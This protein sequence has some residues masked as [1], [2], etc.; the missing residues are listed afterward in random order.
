[1][2]A[3]GESGNPGG[4]PGLIGLPR[5][6]LFFWAALVPL[7]Y[8]PSFV[9]A[10]R[11]GALETLLI[12]AAAAI[13]F[14]AVLGADRVA[15][16]E[17]KLGPAMPVVLGLFAVFYTGI[18]TA[19]AQ[20]RLQAVGDYSQSALFGQ[21][22]WTL[23]HGHPF[24]NT[25][26]TLDGT[27]G[28]HFGVHFSPTLL[29]L[30]PFYALWPRPLVLLAFQS[31]AIALIPV[32]VYALLGPRTGRVAAALF[33]LAAVAMIGLVWAGPI[34]FFDANFLPVLVLAMIWALERRRR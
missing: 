24:A 22:F 13:A 31:L 14:G 1:M 21:S 33:G 19:T 3:H 25:H 6:A 28:S 4:K 5:R 7:A 9:L 27:L 15:P 18:A 34:D 16:L 29:L 8:A 11:P 20:A 17:A 32:P 12:A 30:T 23:L 2:R 10:N 26:E